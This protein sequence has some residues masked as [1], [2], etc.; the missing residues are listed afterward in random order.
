[1]ASPAGG[2][3]RVESIRIIRDEHRSLS[4]VL[5]GMLYLVREIRYAGAAPDFEV[6]RAMVHY[7]EAFSER[8]HHPKEDAYLFRRLRVRCP[9]AGPLL[10]RLH[11]EH[12]VGTE[13]VRELVAALATYERDPAGF[14]G[15]A[16]ALAAY[17]AFH[18]SH[19]RAEE[20]EVL[21]LAR[22]HLGPE[23]WKE[24]DSAFAGHTNP[25]FSPDASAR[26]TQLFRRIVDLAPP[27]IGT[28]AAR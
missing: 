27:P 10:D 1:M 13:K 3:E 8:V 15:F 5:R 4:A 18:Y 25:L 19:M 11:A 21:P 2:G 6:F 26:Y 22:A 20:D 28:G 17:A 9:D 7:L 14:A 24:I 12:A 23:D 16:T